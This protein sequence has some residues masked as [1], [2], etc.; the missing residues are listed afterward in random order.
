[1]SIESNAAGI[2][3]EHDDHRERQSRKPY[4]DFLWDQFLQ[5]LGIEPSDMRIS[6]GVGKFKKGTSTRTKDTTRDV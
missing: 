3:R 2:S 4:E 6:D 5:D 1:M